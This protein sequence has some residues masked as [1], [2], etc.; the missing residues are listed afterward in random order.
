MDSKHDRPNIGRPVPRAPN[1]EPRPHRTGRDGT[2]PH[3]PRI[4]DVMYRISTGDD[5]WMDRVTGRR[6]ARHEG[7]RRARARACADTPVRTAPPVSS[8]LP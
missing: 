6:V 1:P 4:A 8:D 7:P 2:P 5:G 3:P